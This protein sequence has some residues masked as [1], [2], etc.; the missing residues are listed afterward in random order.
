MMKPIK[1]IDR[2][3]RY[4]DDNELVKKQRQLLINSLV[5][6]F[7]PSKFNASYILQKRDLE[8]TRNH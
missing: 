2:E 6:D 7:Y 3:T 8:K 4:D 1:A 5:K